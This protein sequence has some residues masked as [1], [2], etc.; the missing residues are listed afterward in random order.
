MDHSQFLHYLQDLSQFTIPKI[1][2]LLALFVLSLPIHRIYWVFLP[3]WHISLNL[4]PSTGIL[5]LYSA[6]IWIS[7][8][9]PWTSSNARSI[10]LELCI[11]AAIFRLFYA[12]YSEG[13]TIHCL[14]LIS[15]E[16]QINLSNLLESLNHPHTLLLPSA[17]PH[18]FRSHLCSGNVVS[19]A[20]S[21][22]QSA[23]W[24]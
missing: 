2:I 15:L 18:H 16:F 4:I 17:S 23:H 22:V 20:F 6:S 21:R 11:S 1:S 10:S 12:L 19:R 8:K 3:L 9:F 24:Q 14:R 13:N 5:Q 7:Q